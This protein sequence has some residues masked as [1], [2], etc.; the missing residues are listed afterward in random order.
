MNNNNGTIH[1][2]PTPFSY[3]QNYTILVY[4]ITSKQYA[5]QTLVTPQRFYKQTLIQVQTRWTSI[6]TQSTYTNYVIP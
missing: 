3:P 4:I 6:N 1:T 5:S 2:S